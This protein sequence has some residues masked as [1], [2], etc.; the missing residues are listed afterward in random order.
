MSTARIPVS[1]CKEI[2]RL[3][4]NFVWGTSSEARRPTLVSGADSDLNCEEQ[5]FFRLE[6][7]ECNLVRDD[8]LH[9]C[10]FVDS[11]RDWDWSRLRSLIPDNVVN[12]ITTVLPST[13]DVG[14]N[15]LAWKWLSKE[16][17]FSSETYRNLRMKNRNHFV[18]SNGQNCAQSLVDIGLIW[19]KSYATSNSNLFK[20]NSMVTT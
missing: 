2:K 8:T 13:P 17:F 5:L 3:A 15:Q 19:A 1:I 7:V 14:S 16:N 9:V 20:P 10:D 18:F 12:Q 11:N 6:I 4:R